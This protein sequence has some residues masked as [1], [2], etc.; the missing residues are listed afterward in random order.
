M[1]RLG[2]A[3]A[4]LSC[5]SQLGTDA[6]RHLALVEARIVRI[7]GDLDRPEVQARMLLRLGHTVATAS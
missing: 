4:L 6:P 1:A 7:I 5:G 3:S 2:R